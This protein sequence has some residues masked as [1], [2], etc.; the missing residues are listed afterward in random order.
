M[1][2]FLL[3][4]PIA[5]I[6]TFL[7]AFIIGAVTYFALPVSLLPSI[8]IPVITV[9]VSEEG[10]GGRELENIVVG[11]L[12]RQLL[13][14]EG[15]SDVKSETRDG[16]A[17]ISLSF[18]YG[19]SMDL[20]FIDVN[21]KIDAIMGSMP[22]DI[23]RPKV[24]KA[25]AT[26]I[27]VLYLSMSLRR[28]GDEEFQ[29]MADLAENVVRRRLEQQPEIAMADISGVPRQR[30][31]I[32]PDRGIMR[33]QGITFR[34]IETALTDNNV[35]LGTLTVREGC[36]EYNINISNQLS[37]SNDIKDMYI[38]KGERMIKLSEFCDIEIVTS[39]SQGC[40]FTN[41]RRGVSLALIKQGDKKMG[42]F[43]QKLNDIVSELERE[44]PNIEF[45]QSRNQ[46]ELLDYTISNLLQDLIIGFILVFVLTAWFMGD[47]RSSIVIGV[48]I[49]VSVVITFLLFYLFGVSINIISMS[50]LILAVGMMIDNSVIVTENITQYRQRGVSLYDSCCLGTNEMIT[51]LLTSSLTTVAVF[52][53]LIFLSGIAGAICSD[54]AFAIAAGLGVSYIVGIMLLPVLYNIVFKNGKVKQPNNTNKALERLYIRIIDWCFCHKVL[55][56]LLTALTIP[57]SFI[58]FGILP[59]ERM[60]QIEEDDVV[61]KVEWNENINIDENARRVNGLMSSLDTC[62]LKMHSASVGAQDYMLDSRSVLSSSESEIYMK[63]KSSDV[64]MDILKEFEGKLKCSYPLAT[65]HWMPSENIFEKIFST[66]EPELEAKL[67]CSSSQRGDIVSRLLELEGRLNVPST[68][69]RDYYSVLIDRERLKL[70]GIGYTEVL[71]ALSAAFQSRDVGLMRGSQQYLPI[72]ISLSDNSLEEVLSNSMVRDIPLR[73]LVRVNRQNDLKDITS[74]WDGEYVPIR[75]E[76]IENPEKKIRE[77]KKVVGSEENWEVSFAG[78]FFSNRQMIREMLIILGVSL[79]LMYFI[80]CAQFGSFIQPL[81]VLVEIPIDISFALISLWVFGHTLNLMSAIGIIVTCGIVINDSILKLDVI[82]ELRKDGLPLM[83]AIHTGGLRRLRAILM[84]ALT[85]VFSVVPI[86]FTNDMGSELQ[87]P[88][89]ISM[90]GSMIVGTFV[91]IFV[92]PIIYWLIYRKNN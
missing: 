45:T 66:N 56:L 40:S 42:D 15:L 3:D 87:R 26:D 69:M 79:M 1:V 27:P 21:E 89:A 76:R 23:S 73:E 55:C 71:T 44:Y 65:L 32:S 90:I 11:P 7:S 80:L 24:V 4:R 13:Q 64:R 12:R 61:A 2:R 46:T 67:H 85:T 31:Q 77:V 35:S 22:R 52:V 88:F 86:L 6:M 17:T 29:E 9:R 74:G 75:F 5:V 47:A 63:A 58:L 81:I 19:V 28:G 30:I 43:K 41:G 36:Y 50:G 16:I 18:D 60:P 70:Y 38:R 57:L 78:S 83:E 53:P 62:R 20:A 82:N 49:L 34:D 37:D 14:V 48:T 68:P 84:T 10:M 72:T 25:S 51:P 91:S 8:D 92:I 39:N 59:V 54:Q 33:S